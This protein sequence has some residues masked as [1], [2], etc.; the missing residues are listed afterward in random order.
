MNTEHTSEDELFEQ[1]ALTPMQKHLVD[2]I[3]TVIKEGQ[4]HDRDREK[5]RVQER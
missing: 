1:L 5:E 3:R 4:T 2:Y